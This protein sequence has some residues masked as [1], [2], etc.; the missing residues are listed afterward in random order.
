[1]RRA[2]ALAVGAL[3]VSAATRAAADCGVDRPND[4]GGYAGYVYPTEVDS[5]PTKEGHFR[6]WWAKTGVHAP[7]LTSSRPDGVPDRVAIT[8]RE[9]EAAYTFYQSLG[10]RAPPTDGGACAAGGDDRIDVY[11]VDMKGSDGVTLSERCTTKGKVQSCTGAMLVEND[12]GGRGYSGFEQG[13]KTVVP[14]E[15]F[16]MVQHGY[17]AGLDHWF[18]EGT[19]QWATKKL[20][21]EL[22]DLER[23]LPEFFSQLERP[24]DVPPGGVV[25]GYLYGSAA[26]PVF[27]DQA[28]GK[29][30]VREIFEQLGTSGGTVLGAAAP[31]FVART[32]TLGDAYGLFAQW[33]LAVGARA[34]A[35]GGYADAAKYP[36]PVVHDADAVPFRRDGLSA[37]LSTRYYR[38]QGPAD[39]SLITDPARNQ[40]F[41]VPIVAGAADLTQA[42]ALPARLVSGE[43]IVIVAGKSV[44]KTDAPWT[45]VADVPKEELPPPA[46]ATTESSG[47]SMSAS[48]PSSAMA[49]LGLLLALRTR[50][51]RCIVRAA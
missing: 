5:F 14:H 16:H 26:F 15:Y 51:R 23:F 11:L 9:A 32:T 31:V 50:R 22:P 42:A 44:L 4:P 27:L 25:A 33:N 7:L 35:G 38:V 46:P 36:E 49:S 48:S 41:V 13:A 34:K 28:Y 2:V 12:Y 47:C 19:A 8:G 39:L 18:A 17:H 24:L 45:L 6:I 10:Y 30:I 20:H 3:A 1:M 40:G 43:G 29:D 21:P 37:G